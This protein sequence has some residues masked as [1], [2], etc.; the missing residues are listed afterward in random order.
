MPLELNET[1]IAVVIS[2]LEQTED[3]ITRYRDY[4]WKVEIWTLL[5]VLA[6][7]GV[8]GV[9]AQPAVPQISMM[10][11]AC[12]FAVFGGVY[13]AVIHSRLTNS[14]KRQTRLETLLGCF[15]PAAYGD[16]ESLLPEELKD[17]PKFWD[18]GTL[19]VGMWATIALALGCSLL[20][21]WN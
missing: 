5:L 20:F 12:A 11:A 7:G 8:G 1:Q 2:R 10:I 14:R 17:E 18:G 3:E 16:S 19:L 9:A 6:A 15:E 21:I 13:L 4:E